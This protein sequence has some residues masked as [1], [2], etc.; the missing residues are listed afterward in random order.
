[1]MYHYT[2]VT[3]LNTVTSVITSVTVYS[4]LHPPTTRETLQT[5]Q[6][7]ILLTNYITGDCLKAAYI[8]VVRESTDVCHRRACVCHETGHCVW[9]IPHALSLGQHWMV[10][11]QTVVI[12]RPRTPTIIHLV[13]CH[14]PGCV[15]SSACSNTQIPIIQIAVWKC[16]LFTTLNVT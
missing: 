6:I 13:I 3:K 5:H 15:K 8:D 12:V 7:R 4:Q 10:P 9:G 16:V 1:M 14:W 2:T 11:I